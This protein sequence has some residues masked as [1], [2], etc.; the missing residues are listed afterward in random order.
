MVVDNTV[1]T[2]F[3]QNNCSFPIKENNNKLLQSKVVNY[4][5]SIGHS[6]VPPPLPINPPPSVTPPPAIKSNTLKS[7]IDLRKAPVLN[8]TKN[9]AST[10]LANFKQNDTLSS[11]GSTASDNSMSNCSSSDG[12]GDTFPRKPSKLAATENALLSN[13]NNI[14][15]TSTTVGFS[16]KKASELADSNSDTGLSSLHSSSDEAGYTLDTLV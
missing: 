5:E 10:V 9:N 11:R 7:T 12:I 3:L 16:V 14:I 1:E 15:N 8:N 13:N 6:N 2:K 4:D